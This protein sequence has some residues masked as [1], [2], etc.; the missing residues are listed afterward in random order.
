MY[1]SIRIDKQG[2]VWRV[3]L[4]RPE[5]RNAHD[6]DMFKELVAAFDEVENDPACRCAVLTGAGDMF[7]AGQDLRF[8]RSADAQA[9]DAYGR[10][11]VA[12][13]QRIQRNFKPVVAAVNGPAIGGGV[14][15]ATAC[16]LVVSV[17]SAYFQMREIQAGNHSGGA[18]LFTVG[19]ARSLEM[20]L[21]G[22]RVSAPQAE[23][24]GLINRSVPADGFDAAVDDYVHAL[25]E[26]PPLAI[27]YT[28][29]ATNLL[30]DSAGFSTH[31]EASA[32]MQRYLSLSPDGREAKRAF[33]ERRKPRFTGAFPQAA[34]DR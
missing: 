2:S 13:R 7:S 21:L 10:F 31:S 20:S 9:I 28:K 17:D 18:F 27:R 32:P 11:N 22:R 4:N 15:L 34:E 12:A 19:R 6:L 5:V 30:L 23:A 3:V 29:S 25:L 14:Y 24:W 26:L 16:D 8:T 33:N 1:T